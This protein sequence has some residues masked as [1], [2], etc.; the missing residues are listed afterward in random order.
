[1]KRRIAVA[2]IALYLANGWASAS[3]EGDQCTAQARQILDR[4]EQEVVGAMSTSERASANRIV[5]EVCEQR[6][7]EV[8]QE[9]AVAVQEAREEEQEKSTSWWNT[10]ADKPGNERLKRKQH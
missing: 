6:E 1:M 7:T 4:L 10:S 9:K 5:L 2:A 8:V 3:D